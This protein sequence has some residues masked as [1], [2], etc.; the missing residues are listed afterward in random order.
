MRLLI[1]HTTTF[2]YDTPISEAYTE[3]RLRPLD[4]NGQRCLAFRL[5]V[6]PRSEVTQYTDMHGNDV[7]YFDVLQP[8]QKLV[9]AAHSEVFTPEKF[10]DEQR[11]FTLIEAYDYLRPTAYTP[12]TEA[13]CRLAKPL[14]VPG[15]PQATALALLHGVHTAIK[16]TRGVTN[17]K[18]TADDALALG[19]G[20]CQDYTH[21][22][23]AAARCLGLPARYV[24]GYLYNPKTPTDEQATH[25]WLDIYIPEWGWLALDP[26]HDTPQTPRHVRVAVGRDY[27]D[28]SPTHG[29]YTGNAKEQ[30]GVV[31][32]VRE[33]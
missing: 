29:I 8:H 9:V 2:F 25:A 30:M 24:S 21:V 11:A 19:Q 1:E 4:G 28:V 5:S 12:V 3:M 7:R 17:V 33:G 27:A 16:Y 32:R 20:V 22:M 18:T 26:T 6:E 31:V 13:I 14:E 23:L 15:D 10:S